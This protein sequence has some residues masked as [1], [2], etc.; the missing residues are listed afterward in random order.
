MEKPIH[1]VLTVLE[2][3]QAHHS[4]SGAELAE[5]VGVERRTV[6]RYVV[7][8]EKLGVPIQ[9]TRGRDGNYALM[10]G[11][12]LPPL[13][14]SNDETLALSIGLRVARELGLSDMTPAVAST[15]A[16]LDR[17]MPKALQRKI[18]N[19]NAVV[20]LDLSRPQAVSGS[21]FFAEITRCASVGQRISMEYRALDGAL[22]K[23]EVDPYGVGYLYGAWY[24]VG[25]CHKRRDLRSFR[26]DRVQAVSAVP[27]SFAVPKPFDV[28]KHLRES[29]AGIRRIHSIV[30]MLN[31]DL[32]SAQ[33]AIPVSIGKL[34]VQAGGVRLDAQADDLTWSARELSRLNLEFRIIKPKALNAALEAHLRRLLDTHNRLR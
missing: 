9:A 34:T 18:G 8:L 27:K 30:V 1:R 14:F 17:V 13:M 4:L 6:R 2:L 29:I 25:Y 26:L 22:T 16:K 19:L 24:V 31:T 11:Y 23:R 12:K 5:R 21:E 32:A 28:L 10:P 20:S 33:R 15:Q 3:L 7:E